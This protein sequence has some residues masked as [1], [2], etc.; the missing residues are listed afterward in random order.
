MSIM[1]SRWVDLANEIG[2]GFA[3]R[4]EARAESDDFVAENYSVMKQRKL[5]SA[6]VP[7]EFGGGGARHSEICAALRGLARHCPSTALAL[8]MHQHLVAATLYN[9]TKGRPGQKLLEAVGAKELVL[10]STGANDWLESKGEAEKVEGGFRVSAT[11]T[12]A[13]GSPAGD[14]LVTSAPYHDPKE[15]WQVLHFPVSLRSEGVMV[16]AD[17]QAMGMRGS[18]SG[19]VVLNDVFVPEGAIALRRPRGRYHA[20]FNTI[21]VCA[22]PI[23]L[24]VYVGV[25]EAAAERALAIVKRR[26]AGVLPQLLGELE[27]HL[28]TAQLALESM[29]ALANDLDFEPTIERTSAMLTRKTLAANAVIATCAKALEAAGGAGYLRANGLDRLLRD[30]YAAQFHPMQERKQQ[31]FTGRL[32]L[33]LEPIAP[34][35]AA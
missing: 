30:A 23:V 29:V 27:N 18:G 9:H 20:V 21:V 16:N 11:K 17:W 22:M 2:P 31:E 35:A 33:G 5:F 13:S 24:S 25:A 19:S 28:T 26:P 1:G 34:P 12:F 7:P 4:A 15:G 6:L 10:V 8:S 3:A 32:A 14:M